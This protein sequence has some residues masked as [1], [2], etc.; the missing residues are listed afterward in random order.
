MSLLLDYVKTVCA[1]LE[2]AGPLLTDE[3]ALTVPKL[4]Q[5]W[6]AGVEYHEGARIRY[7]EQLYRVRQTHTSQADWPPSVNTASLYARI[8]ETHAGTLDDPIPYDGNMALEKDKYY[9]QNGVIYLCNRSTGAPV[10]NPLADLV[11][12]YVEEVSA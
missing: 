10:F 1:T 9:T 4:Y 6:R 11:G 5:D 2:A 12:L 7:E 3:Q 8:D